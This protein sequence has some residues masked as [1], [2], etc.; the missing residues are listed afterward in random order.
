MTLHSPDDS[1]AHFATQRVV[2]RFTSQSIPSI[3]GIAQDQRANYSEIQ[4]ATQRGFFREPHRAQLQC[5]SR[6]CSDWY[7]TS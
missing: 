1:T 4:F 2:L 6:H 5:R 7:M 3:S